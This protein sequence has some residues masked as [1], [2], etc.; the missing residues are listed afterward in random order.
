MKN[1]TQLIRIP[2]RGDPLRS[3]WFSFPSIFSIL[4]LPAALFLGV[5]MG[6]VGPVYSAVVAGTFIMVIVVLLRLDEFTVT[7]IVAVHILVDTYLGLDVY[8]VA[9]LMALVLLFVCYFGRS[10]DHPWTRPRSSWLWILF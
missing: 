3:P 8:Q 9:M 2:R 5:A 6:T 10:A 7:L 4:A 1:V